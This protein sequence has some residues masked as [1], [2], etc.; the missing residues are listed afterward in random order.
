MSESRIKQKP[1]LKI[2]FYLF[3]Q[4]IQR[5]PFI[6]YSRYPFWHSSILSWMWKGEGTLRKNQIN[7]INWGISQTE[8]KIKIISRSK[9]IIFQNTN[10]RF[11]NMFMYRFNDIS[12]F[13]YSS[14]RTLVLWTAHTFPISFNRTWICSAG[15]I[16]GS[17]VSVAS[18]IQELGMALMAPDKLSNI[19]IGKI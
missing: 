8:S 15:V 16:T 13:S 17:E 7:Q 3:K 12:S 11:M 1:R 5:T 2:V 19:H 4:L 10:S 9:S 6:F 18:T 14:C